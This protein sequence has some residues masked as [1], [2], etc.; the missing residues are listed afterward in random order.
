MNAVLL[1]V[2]DLHSCIRSYA[3]FFATETG[4]RPTADLS[5]SLSLSNHHLNPLIIQDLGYLIQNT[6]NQQLRKKKIYI[7]L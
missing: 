2:L 4:E 7:L 5:L 6:E 3:L 1:L